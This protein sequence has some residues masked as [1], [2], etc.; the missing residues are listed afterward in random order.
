MILTQYARDIAPLA[1]D[2]IPDFAQWLS[3]RRLAPAR[4]EAAVRVARL[5]GRLG[6]GML[7]LR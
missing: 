4:R 2:E 3:Q 6:V 1:D 5:T 7:R